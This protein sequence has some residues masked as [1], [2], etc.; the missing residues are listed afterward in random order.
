MAFLKVRLCSEL[1]SW[2][3]KKKSTLSQLVLKKS[4]PIIVETANSFSINVLI[5]QYKMV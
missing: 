3:K 5:W 1:F 2:G 4:V